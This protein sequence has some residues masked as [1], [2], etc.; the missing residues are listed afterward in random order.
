MHKEFR[1]S[2]AKHPNIEHTY[3]YA[4][5]CRGGSCDNCRLRF[6]CFTGGNI[7]Y[8]IDGELVEKLDKGIK[9]GQKAAR[10]IFFREYLKQ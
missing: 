7:M 2:W 5:R 8:I 1:V 3:S 4:F 10:R 6:L 9:A